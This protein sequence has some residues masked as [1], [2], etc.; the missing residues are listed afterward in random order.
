[1]KHI[2]DEYMRL[3]RAANRKPQGANVRAI[4]E[5]LAIKHGMTYADVRGAIL[6]AT[7]MEAN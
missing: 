5:E 7:V 2:V 3:E 1:M 6:D 4:V